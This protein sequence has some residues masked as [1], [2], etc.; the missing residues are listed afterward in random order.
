[1]AF[2]TILRC[3]IRANKIPGGISVRQVMGSIPIQGNIYIYIFFC[4]IF[5]LHNE[6]KRGFEFKHSTRHADAFRIWRKVGNESVLME[7]ECL[8]T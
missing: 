1:M 4:L 2:T 7:T 6:A 8:N 3:I 5:S